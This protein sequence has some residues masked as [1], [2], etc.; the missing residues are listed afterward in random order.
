MS[1]LPNTNP[2]P[3]PAPPEPAAPSPSFSSSRRSSL[4]DQTQL[5]AKLQWGVV[6]VMVAG[7]L[8]FYLLGYAPGQRRVAALKM[9]IDLKQRELATSRDKVRNLPILLHAV[10]QLDRQVEEYDRKFP[11]QLELGQ[12]IKDLTRLCQQVSLKDW[13]Y[14]PGAPK[15]TE[16]LQE[17]PIVMQF[18]GDFL[19]AANF[20]Q[21][22]ETLQ[23]L[24]RV[25]RLKIR[26]KDAKEGVVDVEATVSIYFAEPN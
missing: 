11:R 6:A 7:L 2:T 22:V 4:K 9:Q 21:Q 26:Q 13:K 10:S 5:F 14:Q 8:G 20:L 23:R 3:A 17:M 18:N 12:F 25:K 24:T 19:S 1:T 16:A 15:R